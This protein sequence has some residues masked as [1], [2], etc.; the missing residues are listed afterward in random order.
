MRPWRSWNDSHPQ[1]FLIPKG[2]RNASLIV[3]RR[4]TPLAI[5]AHLSIYP[6][7]VCPGALKVLSLHIDD[8]PWPTSAP[9]PMRIFSPL[10]S[11]KPALLRPPATQKRH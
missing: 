2:G 8:S 7:E 1:S 11:P 10:R 5:S 4:R 3:R 9:S 6:L